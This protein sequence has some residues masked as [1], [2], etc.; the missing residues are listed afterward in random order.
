MKLMGSTHFSYLFGCC[1]LHT[2]LFDGIL[3]LAPE[4]HF[5]NMLKTRPNEVANNE[6][7]VFCIDEAKSRLFIKRARSF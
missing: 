4:N 5:I 2:F 3:L 1:T 7:E 6:L